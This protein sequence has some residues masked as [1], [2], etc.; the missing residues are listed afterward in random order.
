MSEGANFSFKTVW[1]SPIRSD[2]G[3]QSGGETGLN[4]SLSGGVTPT[5]IA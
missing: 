1:R 3:C 5:E 2:Q 4:G